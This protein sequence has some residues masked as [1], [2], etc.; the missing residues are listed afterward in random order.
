MKISEQ[1]K[2]MSL[3]NSLTEEQNQA[4]INIMGAEY[5]KADEAEE[6]YQGEYS[7]DIEFAQELA[8]QL[9]AVNADSSWPNYCIDWE[10]AARDLMMDY[11][12]DSGYY[13]KNL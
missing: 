5:A 10:Y 2:Q 4:Y 7:T 11:S 9:G 3:E 8:D 12:E 1:A 6:A 13:F